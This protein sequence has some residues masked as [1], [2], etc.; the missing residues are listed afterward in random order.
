MQAPLHS[1]AGLQ[2]A[3][4]WRAACLPFLASIMTARDK[5]SA[6]KLADLPLQ[7]FQS[8]TALFCGSAEDILH[9]QQYHA[10]NRLSFFSI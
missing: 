5:R 6:C 8:A 4:G 3:E 2:G 9:F 10:K 7:G 1:S